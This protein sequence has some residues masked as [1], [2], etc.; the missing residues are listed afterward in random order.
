[1]IDRW[2]NSC[3]GIH[4][5]TPLCEL[6]QEW[7]LLAKLKDFANNLETQVEQSFHLEERLL[8][9]EEV[10]EFCQEGVGAFSEF[11]KGFHA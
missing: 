3:D 6:E 11:L 5:D 7:L 10:A 9:E 1:M 2:E 8:T 4:E